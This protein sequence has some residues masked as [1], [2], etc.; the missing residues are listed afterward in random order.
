MH[1]IWWSVKNSQLRHISIINV[2][3]IFSALLVYTASCR[4]IF[5]FNSYSF[6][7]SYECFSL[8]ATTCLPGGVTT[9][10]RHLF[11]FHLHCAS[12]YILF[13]QKKISWSLSQH[14]FWSLSDWN[15][16]TKTFNSA[17]GGITSLGKKKVLK[18]V[19]AVA[20]N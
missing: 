1:F 2:T 3:R 4:N 18:G 14:Q 12:R 17:S 7:C 5:F 13:I 19:I 20:Y 6:V 16:P 9:A 8:M 10:Q 11:T 15:Q